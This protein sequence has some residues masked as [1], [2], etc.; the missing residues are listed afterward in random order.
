M[1]RK[2]RTFWR[3]LKLWWRA[4]IWE[5]FRKKRILRENLEAWNRHNKRFIE[6]CHRKE[7]RRIDR[8]ENGPGADSYSAAGHFGSDCGDGG[9]CGF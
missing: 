8:G 1:K 9:F 6:K 2:R 4:S 5:E 7:C 3:W